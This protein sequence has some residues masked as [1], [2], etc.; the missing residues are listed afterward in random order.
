M[1]SLE[2]SRHCGALTTGKLEQSDSRFCSESYN[3]PEP[4]Q[5]LLYVFENIV[6]FDVFTAVTMKNAVFWNIKTF[7][8]LI[9]ETLR[10]GYRAQPVNAM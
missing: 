9:G 7:S 4:S 1:L 6:R 2:N 8:Y 5:I 10:F 3:F